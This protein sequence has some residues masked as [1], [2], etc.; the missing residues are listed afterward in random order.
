MKIRNA[1][2]QDLEAVMKIYAD[3]ACFM[4]EN[5]NPNQWKNGY[6][7]LDLVRGDIEESNLYV[8]VEK[9]DILGV[10][11]YKYAEDECYKKIYEGEWKNNLPYGVI[12]RIAVAENAHGMGVS[13]FCFDF[14]FDKCHNLKI[15]THK[16]NKVMQK[17]LSK[18]MFEVCGKIYLRNG[19]ERIAYQK[20]G[21]KYIKK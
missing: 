2:I 12:H 9:D 6:P 3:A 5:G 19:E 20:S 18:N 13:R 14:A 11:Y 8:C 17:A 15:D 21:D 16:D 7:S 4:K 10:F 1:K